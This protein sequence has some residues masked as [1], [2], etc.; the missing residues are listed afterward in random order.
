LRLGDHIDMDV[1][2]RGCEDI[3]W[4]VLNDR[5]LITPSS[6]IQVVDINCLYMFRSAVTV[7]RRH[8]INMFRNY[9]YKAHNTY[10]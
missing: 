9:Y 2:K 3:K 8:K 4:G 6:V 10:L 1:G 5:I 7:F